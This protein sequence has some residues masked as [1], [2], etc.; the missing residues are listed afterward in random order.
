MFQLLRVAGIPV[1]VDLSWLLVFALI[2]WSLAAGYFPR[3]LA[4]LS[5]G[6]A[7]F[8][9]MAAAAL[10]FVSVFLHELFHALVAREQGVRVLGIRLHVFGGV[11]E[12]E[13]EPPTPGAECLIAVVGPLVSFVL[14]ALC[15]GLGGAARSRPWALAL[16]G[17]LVAVNLVVGLFN[18]VPGLPL[19]GGRLLRAML[20]WWSGRLDWAT[21]WARRAG[22]AFAFI[23]VA[24]G[25]ARGLG[26]ETIG[27][28]WFVLI[29]LFL[30]RAARASLT[31]ASE[32]ETVE[33]RDTPRR[34]A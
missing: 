10:L 34:A 20:W 17:Y 22:W 7:W 30:Y 9:G 32:P 25:V 26:G 5:T 19:D 15:Y 31:P 21:R 6:G 4:P 24:I 29:G 27:G 8:H 3:V 14:A 12:L 16:T 33:Q 28:L 2:S 1:R 18:L 13:S 11:S 23:L